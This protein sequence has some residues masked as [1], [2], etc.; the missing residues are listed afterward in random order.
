[1]EPDLPF[2]HQNLSGRGGGRFRC[3]N[4]V[5]M[6]SVHMARQATALLSERSYE[7]GYLQPYPQRRLVETN[8]IPLWHWKT[9]TYVSF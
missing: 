1:M 3:G 4:I 8:E 5:T 2:N 9:F 6:F 7:H